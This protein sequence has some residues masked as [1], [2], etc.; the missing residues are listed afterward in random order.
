MFDEIL[1]K[2]LD[3]FSTFIEKVKKVINDKKK[4]YK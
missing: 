4:K 1:Y 2:I 3:S